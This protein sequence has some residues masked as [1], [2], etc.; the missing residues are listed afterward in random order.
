VQCKLYCGKRCGNAAVQEVVAARH[1]YNAQI[2]VVVCP[3]GFTPVARALA[4]SNG[5]HRAPCA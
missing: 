1:P 4:A 2:M 3:A 5:V